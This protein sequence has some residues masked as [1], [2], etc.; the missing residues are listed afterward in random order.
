M[1]RWAP[2]T[3]SLALATAAAWFG[4]QACGSLAGEPAP[5][6]TATSWALPADLDQP[7][8]PNQGWRVLAFFAPD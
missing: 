5:P 2:L 7:P 1:R 3:V 8:D 4:M 6:V